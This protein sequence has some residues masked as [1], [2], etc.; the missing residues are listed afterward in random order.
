[1]YYLN[2]LDG[3]GG[4]WYTDGT[5]LAYAFSPAPSI[6]GGNYSGYNSNTIDFPAY[7][8]TGNAIARAVATVGAAAMIGSCLSPAAYPSKKED[9]EKLNNP[10]YWEAT[11]VNK[12]IVI[13]QPLSYEEALLEVSSLRSIMCKDQYA[14]YAIIVGGRYRNA[15]GPERGNKEGYYWHYHPTRNHTG[16]G[17]IHIWFYGEAITDGYLKRG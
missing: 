1:M 14:A 5:S 2:W 4:E 6:G 11:L 16:Y 10:S 13:G 8:T 3:G 9:D 12:T 15:V 17:S 7:S